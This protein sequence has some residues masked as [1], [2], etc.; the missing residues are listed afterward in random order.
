MWRRIIAF[1]FRLRNLFARRRVVREAEQEI[2]MH[3]DLL[4]A[5]YRHAG[6]SPGESRRLARAKFGGVTQLEESLRDQAGSIRSRW[7][8]SPAGW[9]S[10]PSWPAGF[11]P[12]GRRSPTP[13]RRS[14]AANERQ[15]GRSRPPASKP[16][17]QS[18]RHSVKYSASPQVTRSVPDGMA[19]SSAG[20]SGSSVTARL[21]TGPASSRRRIGD[22][23]KSNDGS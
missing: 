1:V 6:R 10:W 4:T 2:E 21:R 22:R 13:R 16:Y 20:G 19:P 12:D 9:R 7:R 3:L 5:Q 18:I 8:R 17:G 23:P 14:E 15:A 11:P